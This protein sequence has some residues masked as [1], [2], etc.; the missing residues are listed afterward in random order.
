MKLKSWYCSAFFKTNLC[1][2][3]VQWARFKMTKQHNG[4]LAIVTMSAARSFQSAHHCHAPLRPSSRFIGWLNLATVCALLDR[5]R[6]FKTL[7][8]V[9]IIFKIVLKLF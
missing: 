5:V 3:T 8:C 1:L 6:Y 4:E 7:N 9:K 2:A